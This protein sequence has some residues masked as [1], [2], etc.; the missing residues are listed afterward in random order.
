MIITVF[1]VSIPFLLTIYFGSYIL[2]LN[3]KDIL[4]RIIFLICFGIALL[5]LINILFLFPY[6]CEN[7]K[8]EYVCN[9]AKIG[10]VIRFNVYFLV[11]LFGIKITRLVPNKKL[12]YLILYI[13]IQFYLHA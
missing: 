4:N 3:K 9:I 11:L 6:I 5:Y 7:I 1:V 8:E 10:H 2:F 12:I 13:P